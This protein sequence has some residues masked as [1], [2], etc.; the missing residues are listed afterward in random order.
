[1]HDEKMLRFGGNPHLSHVKHFEYKFDLNV[2]WPS[3]GLT[4]FAR[5][6]K[7]TTYPHLLDH[8]LWPDTVEVY[9]EYYR[10]DKAG[11]AKWQ[12]GTSA[13]DW[14]FKEAEKH[15]IIC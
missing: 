1:M 7:K 6:I 10:I 12:R 9:R 5:A 8:E 13:P 4:P 15:D 11:F 14:W 3:R 2:D